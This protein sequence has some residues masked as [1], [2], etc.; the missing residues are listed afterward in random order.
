M[1]MSKND[2]A[3]RMSSEGGFLSNVEPEV[4]IFVLEALVEFADG[5]GGRCH[6]GPPPLADHQV[7]GLGR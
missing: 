2:K 3:R 6:F 1:G 4:A 7:D 5:A